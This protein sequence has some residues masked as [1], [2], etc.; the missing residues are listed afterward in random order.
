MGRWSVAQLERCG[1]RISQDMCNSVHLCTIYRGLRGVLP[2]AAVL[3]C[4][5][6][7]IFANTTFAQQGAFVPI[8]NMNN[9]RECHTATLL[10]KG[11]VLVAGGSL[12]NG[13]GYLATTELYDPTTGTF[14]DTGSLNAARGCHT[15]TLLNDGKVLVAGGSVDGTRA[16]ASSELYDPAT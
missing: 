12:G 2:Q 13:I 14:T 6:L 4:A 9:P 8:S 16:L 1:N 3:L 11:K 10:N 5:G 15:A 7:T